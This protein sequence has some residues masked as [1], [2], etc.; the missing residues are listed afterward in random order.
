V[1]EETK[2][3]QQKEEQAK[4]P[5]AESTESDT[6]KEIK[7]VFNMQQLMDTLNSALHES[8]VRRIKIKNR[9]GR[10]VID[11]PVWLAAA[12]GAGAVIASAGLSI[13]GLIVGIAMGVTVEIERVEEKD[14]DQNQENM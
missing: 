9:E 5:S 12:G 8:T 14:Q 1:E 11:V 7:R 13:V 6:I 10:V 2:D 4:E 3:E